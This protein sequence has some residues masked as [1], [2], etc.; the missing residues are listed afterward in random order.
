MGGLVELR[1]GAFAE[2]LSFTALER[3]GAAVGALETA[4][5]DARYG[6]AQEASGF[7]VPSFAVIVHTALDRTVRRRALERMLAGLD[8][9]IQ[10]ASLSELVGPFKG[11][12]IAR[13]L[14]I[15]P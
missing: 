7:G 10:S 11:K 13:D 4:A 6:V 14:P 9:V 2:V 3:A 12:R 5:V 1:R 8:F 15:L